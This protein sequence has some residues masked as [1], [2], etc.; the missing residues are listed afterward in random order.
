MKES[1]DDFKTESPED[2]PQNYCECGNP[3]NEDKDY[4]SKKCLTDNM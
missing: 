4:C 2:I 1:L 3:I